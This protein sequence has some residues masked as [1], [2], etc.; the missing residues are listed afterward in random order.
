MHRNLVMWQPNILSKN[1]RKSIY[2]KK[3]NRKNIYVN[4]ACFS[5]VHETKLKH[6][7]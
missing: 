2:V 5:Y 7:I 4:V 3:V 6:Y 1:I